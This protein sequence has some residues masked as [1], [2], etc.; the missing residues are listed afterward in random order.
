MCKSIVGKHVCISFI[1]CGMNF[2]FISDF[3]IYKTTFEILILPHLHFCKKTSDCLSLVGF[4]VNPFRIF[5]TTDNQ[6]AHHSD[7]ITLFTHGSKLLVTSL[8]F[9]EWLIASLLLY[10]CYA[11]TQI[12]MVSIFDV[13]P[14]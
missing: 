12:V 6:Y 13:V 5:C 9:Y 7:C 11:V 3:K 4:Y 2:L 10:T 1:I 8:L 14:L